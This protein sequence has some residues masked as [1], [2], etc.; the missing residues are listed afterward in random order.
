MTAFLRAASALALLGAAACTTTSGAADGWPDGKEA[1]AARFRAHV[2]TLA[3]DDYE[4]REAG[5]PGYDKAVAYV[6]ERFAELGVTPAGVDGGYL[7]QV[8]LRRARVA[9]GPQTAIR[10]R[11]PDGEARALTPIEDFMAMAPTARDPQATGAAVALT[12]QPLAFVGYGID[13]PSLGVDSYAGVDVAGRV[14]VMTMDMPDGLPSEEG[15][16]WAGTAA[17]I[18]AALRRGATGVVFVVDAPSDEETVSRRRRWAE[19]SSDTFAGRAPRREGVP[20]AYVFRDAAEAMFAASGRAFDEVMAEPS[21]FAMDGT[22]D[23]A[24]AAVFENYESPNV[25]GMIEGT[26]PALRDEVVVLSAHLDHVGVEEADDEGEDDADTIHNGAMDNATGIATLLE[27]A[28]KFEVEGAPKRSVLLLAVTAEEKGLLG[29][30]YFARTPTAAR[31]DIVANVNLDMP[32]LLYDFEDVI[33]FGA[34]HSTLKGLVAEAAEG[35][36]VALTPDPYPEMVLF[37]RSDHYSF[38]KQGVPSVFLFLGT[39][40]G[41]EDAFKSFMATH[42]HRVSDQPDLPILYDVAAKFAELNYRIARGIANADRR[43][44]W[45]DGDFFGDL[46]AEEPGV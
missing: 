25:A 27:V 33:A 42:Y 16:H 38:V 32:V 12:D 44:D 21:A 46:Y 7:Q 40:N 4:G 6:T 11:G 34:E 1:S 9:Y 13:A 22:I 15:A 41:G 31:R 20:S 28:A 37:V 43:P 29:S 2:E 23:L 17:R 19:A 36:G 10:F 39:G 5:T 8:P 18:D 14:A 30:D 3:S 26:D 24:A 45:N 35:M